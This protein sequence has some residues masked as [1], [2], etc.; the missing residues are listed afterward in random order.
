MRHWKAP[1]GNWELNG[2]YP[3]TRNP[4]PLTDREKEQ[5]TAMIDAGQRLRLGSRLFCSV[6]P[7]KAELI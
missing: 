1:A 2:P 5:L 4:L 6:S 3:N 7:V